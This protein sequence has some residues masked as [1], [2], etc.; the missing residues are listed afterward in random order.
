MNRKTRALSRRRLHDKAAYQQLRQVDRTWPEVIYAMLMHGRSWPAI[1]AYARR[2]RPSRIEW[3]TME[4]AL[5]YLRRR[6][7]LDRTF[8]GGTV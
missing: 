2:H 4:R 7:I 8:D 1:R 5:R 6:W 3:Q